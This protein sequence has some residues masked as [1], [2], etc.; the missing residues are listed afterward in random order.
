MIAFSGGTSLEGTLAAIHGGVCVDFKLM[1]KIIAV[2]KDD[3]DVVVQPAV[4]YVE[5]N[6]Q[7]AAHNLFFPPDPGPGA[8]IGGMISQ[9]CS[10][11]NAYRYGTVKDW[12][13]GLTIV[14]ADGTVVKTRHRPRKSSS[15][16]N[17]TQLMVGS[18]GTLGFVTEASLK[19]TTKQENVKVALAAFP[20][21]HKAV[22]TAVKVM[23]QDLQ[24]AA[25]E[26]VCDVGMRAVN[27]SGYCNKEYEEAPTLFLKFAGS[28]NLVKEQIARVQQIAQNSSCQSFEFST[29]DEEADSIWEARKTVLFSII[30]LKKDPTDQFLS[31]DTAVPISRLADAVEISR[32]RLTE[33]GLVGVFVGHLG[34]GNFHTGV[35]YPAHEKQKARDMIRE[36]QRLAI[37]MDGTVTGEHGIGLEYCDM[38]VEELGQDSVNLMRQVKL[39][40]D[41]LC[42]L[43]PDKL[44]K[45]RI[46]Q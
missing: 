8:Q 39:A 42:L 21:T 34:D 18:E 35:I 14:L 15:G 38:V 10:G 23:Q 17:L 26:M 36:I 40:L 20:T 45:L 19:L 31:S 4:P 2:H 33:S 22:E 3:M 5:L 43:N 37:S 6:Q 13:L 7:L 44:F 41:P 12:V 1:N 28:E 25:M 30:A 9:G 46:V 11:T 27:L 32:K 24:L 16:Y 29:T